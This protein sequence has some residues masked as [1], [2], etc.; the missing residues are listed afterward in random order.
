VGPEQI[1][2]HVEDALDALARLAYEIYELRGRSAG[3]DVE[4]W[5]RAEAQL[6]H[7]ARIEIATTARGLRLRADVGGF[8]ASELHVCVEPRRVT[9]VGQRRVARSRQPRTVIIAERRSERILRYVDLPLAVDAAQATAVLAKGV[10]ELTLPR[11]AA[12]P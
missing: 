8:R 6:L 2:S 4:D 9:I 12:A 11:A 10:C 1:R 5:L 7:P 3:R